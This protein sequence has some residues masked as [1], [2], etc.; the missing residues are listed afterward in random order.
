MERLSE[1]GE[2]R[3]PDPAG[4]G[5]DPLRDARGENPAAERAP[6]DP[7]H[8]T[9]SGSLPGVGT[10]ALSLQEHCPS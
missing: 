5:S 10:E 9:G 3:L 7:D 6:R 2:D 8:W 4:G 1:H